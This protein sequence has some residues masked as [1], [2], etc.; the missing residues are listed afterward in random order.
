MSRMGNA[1]GGRADGPLS[2]ERTDQGGSGRRFDTR[3]RYLRVL[4]HE[5]QQQVAA[6]VG[7]APATYS[8][9]ERGERELKAEHIKALSRH[10]RV[11]PSVI[12]NYGEDVDTAETLSE[13][14]RLIQLYRGASPRSRNIARDVLEMGSKAHPPRR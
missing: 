14:E 10:F 9:W 11:S 5:T 2:E 6:D 1:E 4:R 8:S 7:V 3:L 13:L 12:L